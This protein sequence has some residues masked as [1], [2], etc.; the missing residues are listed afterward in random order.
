M[1][2]FPFTFEEYQAYVFTLPDRHA[3]VQYA[4]VTLKMRGPAQ[5][6]LLADVFFENDIR[7]HVREELDFETPA[8]I[9]DYSYEVWQGE[10]KLYWYDPQP[11]PHIPTLQS[12]HPHHKH[13]SPDIKHNRIPAP[14]LS[15]SEPNIPFL[16]HEIE[17]TLL[18]RDSAATE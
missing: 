3:S 12:T 11:H 10:Q 8:P 13:V 6:T 18:T 7:L 15:F 14:D 5:A 4:Q 1:Q 16:I 17:E 9:R 2:P